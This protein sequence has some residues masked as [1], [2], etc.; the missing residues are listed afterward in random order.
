MLCTDHPPI[1]NQR[2]TF[3]RRSESGRANVNVNEGHGMVMGPTTLS[4]IGTQHGVVIVVY[5]RES[6]TH[7]R[8]YKAT[9]RMHQSY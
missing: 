3:L 1:Y 8:E 5:P 6:V 9:T 7:L 4:T 2:M